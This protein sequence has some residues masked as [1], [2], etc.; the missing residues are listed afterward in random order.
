MDPATAEALRRF[1]AERGLDSPLL[2]LGAAKEL[3][4]ISTDF[5]DL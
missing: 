5:E 4:L 2:S 3:G 1:Q